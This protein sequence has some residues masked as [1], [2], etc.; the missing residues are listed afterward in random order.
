MGRIDYTN[1]RNLR[2]FR[3]GHLQGLDA[4]SSCDFTGMVV[5]R[6]YR[7]GRRMSQRLRALV[8]AITNLTW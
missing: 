1:S 2:L 7:Q 8:L 6:E 3:M 5:R 4:K